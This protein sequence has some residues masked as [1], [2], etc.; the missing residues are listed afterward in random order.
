VHSVAPS[1]VKVT[2]PVAPDAR[3]DAERPTVP[4]ELVLDGA[5]EAV[6]EVVARPTVKLVRAAEPS[7]SVSPE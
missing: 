7:W 5:A 4:P 2:L 6:I 3:P 1:E